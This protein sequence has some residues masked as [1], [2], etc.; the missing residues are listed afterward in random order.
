MTPQSLVDEFGRLDATD[1]RRLRIATLISREFSHVPSLAAT[2]GQ[3]TNEDR[4]RTLDEWIRILGNIPATR[5]SLTPNADFA[6]T[7]REAAR[8]NLM[9]GGTEDRTPHFPTFDAKHEFIYF[10]TQCTAAV[11]D[12]EGS[13][14]LLDTENPE[15]ALACLA[16]KDRHYSKAL[17]ASFIAPERLE[18]RT[19]LLLDKTKLRAALYDDATTFDERIHALLRNLLS[20][21]LPNETSCTSLATLQLLLTQCWEV[22]ALSYFLARSTDDAPGTNQSQWHALLVNHA[23]HTLS[24]NVSSMSLPC[25]ATFVKPALQHGGVTATRRMFFNAAPRQFELAVF[26]PDGVRHLQ[27]DALGLGMLQGL[28]W[29]RFGYFK[30][31]ACEQQLQPASAEYE[32]LQ[33]AM[34]GSFD[35]EGTDET[36][37]KEYFRTSKGWPIC[38]F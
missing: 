17:L 7:V 4:K 38:R 1:P 8:V 6:T 36:V 12:E 2:L 35:K 27:H 15:I 16:H 26:E 23:A 14:R 34:L 29:I 19:R 31:M 28:T 33:K 11:R 10:D 37:S 18:W 24:A 3:W 20:A 30:A 25:F 13:A 9:H 21:G 5:I 32:A 22:N